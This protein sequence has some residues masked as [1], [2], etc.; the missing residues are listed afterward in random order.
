[1]SEEVRLSNTITLISE[2]LHLEVK[3]L[4]HSAVS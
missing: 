1:M 3:E 2:A 4:I